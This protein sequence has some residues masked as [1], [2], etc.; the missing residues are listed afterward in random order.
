[1]S[2]SF[3]VVLTVMIILRARPHQSSD[4]D[5]DYSDDDDDELTYRVV[6][7]RAL[8]VLWS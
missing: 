5:N 6:K 8:R 7:N 4:D 2:S 3:G 1:M